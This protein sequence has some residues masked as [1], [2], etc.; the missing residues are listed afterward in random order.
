MPARVDLSTDLQAPKASVT[1]ALRRVHTLRTLTRGMLAIEAADGDH[2]LPALWPV[3]GTPVTLRIRPFYLPVGWRHTIRVVEADPARGILRTEESGG[4]VRRWNHTIE[5]SSIDAGCTRYRDLVELDA[6][7]LTPVVAV[8]AQAFYRVR[9]RRW[10][11][12]ARRLPSATAAT[13]ERSERS[14]HPR[15]DHAP[16]VH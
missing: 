14:A 6:G 3:D 1:A 16:P 9:Q 12:L 4:A 5:V 7:V 10:R 11:A 15:T 13:T 2:P 8:W